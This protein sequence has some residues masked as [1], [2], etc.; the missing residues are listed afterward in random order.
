MSIIISK[1]GKN[2]RRLDPSNFQSEDYLQN[3]I[4]ENPDAVPLYEIKENIN[5]LILA[6][7]F[8]TNSGPIDAIGVDKDGDIYLIETKLYKNPDKRTVVAQVMDYGAS[9]WKSSIDFNQFTAK[10][11]EGTQKQFNTE[12][13][14]KLSEYFDLDDEGIESL[15]SNLQTNLNK[16]NFQF[17]VLMDKLHSQLKDLMIFI[18]ENSRFTIYAVELE[19]YKFEDQEIMIPRLFGAEVK[20]NIRTSSSNAK[21]KWNEQTT[22]Q[23]AKERL[24]NDYMHFE[25][26]YNFCKNNADQINFGS[27]SF[28]SFSPIFNSIS[29]KSL[30][31]LSTDKRL[32]INFEW[33]ARDNEKSAIEFKEKLGKLGFEFT[34]DFLKTRPAVLIEDWGPKVDKILNIIQNIK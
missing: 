22:L 25:K 5:L 30:V 23:D 29:F 15:L 18:N 3:Y 13:N 19:Y 33:I 1:D 9:L 20:K 28:A 31:T 17:V 27:G 4:Y 12:L 11:N 14:Q 8:S 10:L 32:A 34:D 7:E 16:G 6:R 21:Q 26:F 2:A 24:G